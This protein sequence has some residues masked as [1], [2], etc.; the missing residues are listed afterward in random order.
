MVTCAQVMTDPVVTHNTSGAVFI[1]SSHKG[2]GSSS[3]EIFSIL[4]PLYRR[5]KK[6]D[7]FWKDR[8]K[9]VKKLEKE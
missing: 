3:T 6:Y 2:R 8:E 4:W 9:E 7:A 1:L 5:M